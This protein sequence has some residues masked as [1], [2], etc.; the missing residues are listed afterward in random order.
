MLLL[1]RGL[2]VLH[3][4]ILKYA[5]DAITKDDAGESDPDSHGHTYLL[6]TMYCVVR[7]LA[8][9][10]NNIREI[11]FA[12]VSASAEIYIAHLVYNHI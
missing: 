4:L 11:P 1:S 9:F 6:V 8:D 2:N 12:N 7:F 3:P 10:V 5:I